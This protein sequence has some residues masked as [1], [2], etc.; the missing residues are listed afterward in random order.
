MVFG[1]EQKGAFLKL[2]CSG[3]K[4]TYDLTA[5]RSRFGRKVMTDDLYL[6]YYLHL[7]QD[8]LF[9]ALFTGNIIGIRTPTET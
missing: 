9:A 8:L 7:V 6:G 3:T 1:R 2:I 4:K 5:F